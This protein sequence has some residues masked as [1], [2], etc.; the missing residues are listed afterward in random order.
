VDPA[1]EADGTA[2][3]GGAEVAAVVILQH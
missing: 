2:F 1:G 3:V